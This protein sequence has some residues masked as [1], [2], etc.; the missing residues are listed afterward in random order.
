VASSGN[1]NDKVVKTTFFQRVHL[2]GLWTQAQYPAT[3]VFGVVGMQV[4]V[5]EFGRFTLPAVGVMLVM[6]P[7]GDGGYDWKPA[8]TLGF[9]YRITD[10]VFP[11]VKKRA[12]LHINLARTSI[13]GIHDERILPSLNFN[14]IGLSI[15]RSR[16]R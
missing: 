5:F 13:H 9:G 16:G 11:L 4:S 2:T 3:A 8:T 14:L 15:S 1:V 7:D 10:F 6:V 12:S